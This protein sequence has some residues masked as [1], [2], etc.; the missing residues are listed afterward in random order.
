M[1]DIARTRSSACTP[2]NDSLPF[3]ETERGRSGKSDAEKIPLRVVNS[4]VMSVSN[5]HK[6]YR[7]SNLE[8]PVLKGVDLQV[9]EGAFTAIVGQSGSG[10]STLLHLLGTLDAPDQ[11]EIYFQ[12]RRID[13]L[14]SRHKERL[15]NREFG[16]IFQFYHL[17]PELSTLENVLVPKMVQDGF[18]TYLRNKTAYKKRAAELLESVGMGHRLTHKPNQLSG[19]EMQRTAIA[20][21][22]I[23]DPTVLLADEPTGNLDSE[24]GREVMDTLAALRRHENLTVIMVT[25]DD[26]LAAQADHV[27]QLVNGKVASSSN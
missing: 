15:R 19:G 5:L 6:S 18:W 10:K 12:E 24:N 11:G 20:R 21:A 3:G 8:V 14:P 26:D 27:V 7:K 22:L 2:K 25:H 13:N 9:N 16:M 1:S 17:L 23:S 4:T